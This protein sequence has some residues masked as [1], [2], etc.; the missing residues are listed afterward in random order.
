MRPHLLKLFENNI[1]EHF[2]QN[3]K[4]VN[5]K[6]VSE[7]DN[8]ENLL[9][10]KRIKKELDYNSNN[11]I[12]I[13]RAKQVECYKKNIIYYRIIK[14]CQKINIKEGKICNLLPTINGTAQK[15][16]LCSTICKVDNPLIIDRYLN[17]LEGLGKISLKKLNKLL[18]KINMCTREK[19]IQKKKTYRKLLYRYIKM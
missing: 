15:N 4:K 1:I 2:P 3:L 13:N 19:F 16:W 5:H 9:A 17:L 18:P 6:R 12:T 8:F 10:V 11:E 14:I 7:N